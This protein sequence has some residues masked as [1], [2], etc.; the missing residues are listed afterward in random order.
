MCSQVAF[1]N[2]RS[3]WLLKWP[4]AISKR[5]I[6]AMLCT[7]GIF[8]F[9]HAA[10][11]EPPILKSTSNVHSTA[12]TS[13]TIPAEFPHRL[14]ELKAINQQ[15]ESQIT[16]RDAQSTLQFPKRGGLV[17]YWASWCSICK[18]QIEKIRR[19]QSELRK[20][21][22]SVVGIAIEEDQKAAQRAT[23]ANAYEFPVFWTLNES[24]AREVAS[25]ERIPVVLWVD[26]NGKV[27]RRSTGQEQLRNLLNNVQMYLQGLPAEE[28]VDCL[29]APKKANREKGQI[30]ATS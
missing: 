6:A 13:S 26:Q 28:G 8:Q 14:S 5:E 12:P 11:A 4:T 15:A 20:C 7:L 22:M 1:S 23:S 24:Q 10:N 29:S 3:F 25:I 30:Y 17:I 18:A 27:R 2:R 16:K 9:A 19:I 21:D